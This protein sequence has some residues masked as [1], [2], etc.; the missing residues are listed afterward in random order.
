MVYQNPSLLLPALKDQKLITATL[1]G[2]LR[3]S[4]YSGIPRYTKQFGLD[5]AVELADFEFDHVPVIAELVKKENIDCDFTLTRTFDIYTDKD[6]AAEAKKVYLELKAAG[7]A[8]TTINDLEWTDADK[9][10]AVNS[11]P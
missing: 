11:K 7:V 3:P 2:H 1:G 8:K 5:A 9:A 4:V 10:E 6:A